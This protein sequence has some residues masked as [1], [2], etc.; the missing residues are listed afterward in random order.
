MHTGEGNHHDA[1]DDGEE[2]EGPEAE[3]IEL[4]NH[5]YEQFTITVE[6]EVFGLMLINS[7]FG[8]DVRWSLGVCP[9]SFSREVLA[10]HC[11]LERTTIAQH[12][13]TNRQPA[14]GSR[15]A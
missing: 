8:S 3:L 15:E 11:W 5:G 2:V 7:L 4:A 12:D 13:R 1:G 14:P 10:Q 9:R 6:P